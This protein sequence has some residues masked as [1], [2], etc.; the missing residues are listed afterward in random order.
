MTELTDREKELINYVIRG[1]APDLQKMKYE[2]ETIDQ[3]LPSRV[4]LVNSLNELK[5]GIVLVD[6]FSNF[7]LPCFQLQPAIEAVAE[8]FDGQVKFIRINIEKT[9]EATEAF[10]ISSIPLVVVLK[11]GEVIQRLE[12]SPR[13]KRV[14]TI[15]WM[16]QRAFVP[17]DEWGK[18][19]E[20]V[21][22]VAK[23]KGWHLNP[24]KMVAEG[25]V[26]ALTWN[27]QNYG[28]R[29]CPCKSEH[30][31]ENICPCRE[32]EGKYLGADRMI[33]K[34]GLCYCGLF[35]S[36]KYIE[37][38]NEARKKAMSTEKVEVKK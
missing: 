32:V 5:K 19:Y 12:G 8:E 3:R 35:V 26:T 20:I 2:I 36:D 25:L 4:K 17:Q 38:W 18:T 29:F 15:R 31:N 10:N 34:N 33:K 9:R 7:C 37:A 13:Y 21:S 6:F 16:V 14:D 30:M 23:A 24:N 27:L 11:D 28:K 22:K 1:I